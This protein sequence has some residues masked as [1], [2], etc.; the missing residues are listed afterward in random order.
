MKP[1]QRSDAAVYFQAGHY[2]GQV[3]RPRRWAALESGGSS[4]ATFPT[5]VSEVGNPQFFG[6]PRGVVVARRARS[7]RPYI[8]TVKRS[9]AASELGGSTVPKITD[10]GDPIT[11][12]KNA[13]VLDLSAISIMR[14]ANKA[15]LAEF[16]DTSPKTIDGWVRRG[17]PVVK[18]GSLAD[19]WVFDALLVAQWKFDAAGIGDEINPDL[20]IPTDRKAWYE[21]ENK[22]RDLQER[23]RE[24]IPAHEVERAVAQAFAALAQDVRAIPDN[25]ERRC[26]LSG[27]VAETVEAALFEAMD[28][29]ADRLAVLAVVTN[30]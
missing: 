6:S 4:W 9:P 23:D 20:M 18:R 10:R 26:G 30:E 22:R 21:S 29:I 19:P 2:T 1:A 5:G 16:F 13:R 15:Q 7:L 28:S 3:I 27:D 12:A 14:R 25:L 17:C 24:L 8:H 11:K